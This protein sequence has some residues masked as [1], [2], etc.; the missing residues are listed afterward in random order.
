MRVLALDTTTRAGSVALIDNG[1]VVA[2]RRGDPSRSYAERLPGEILS[3]LADQGRRSSDIDLFAVASGP[4]SFTG[5]RVGIATIQ[6]LAFVHE[7]RVAAVSALDALAQSAGRDLPAGAV[8][9]IWTD[10][11]RRDVFTAL[12]QI[13]SEPAFTSARLHQIDPAAVG[14]PA[15]TLLRWQPM[16]DARPIVFAGDASRQY[17]DLIRARR[18]D[19]RILDSPP[20]AGVIGLMAAVMAEAGDVIAPAEIR[21]LYIRRPDAEVDREKRA[22]TAKDTTAKVTTDTKQELR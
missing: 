5:L 15:A 12:Y 16:I 17:H 13:G 6:G 10:A 9:G 21:P 2:E 20:L 22:F 19:A 18:P 3:L 8:V 4:G 14:D 7:R 1:R 11:Q